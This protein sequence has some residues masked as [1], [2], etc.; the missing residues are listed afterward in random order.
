MKWQKNKGHRVGRRWRATLCALAAGM[1]ATPS[2]L[3]QVLITSV[4]D[5]ALPP[6]PGGGSVIGLEQN[7]SDLNLFTTKFYFN[8]A[9]GTDLAFAPKTDLS[10]SIPLSLESVVATDPST[11]RP[12]YLTARLFANSRLYT[13]SPSPS[14][15][16]V[17]LQGLSHTPLPTGLVMANGTLFYSRPVAVGAG[18]SSLDLSTGAATST[19]GNSGPGT[20]NT[21]GALAVGPDG[22]IYVL[23]TGDHRVVSFDTAGN[24]HSAFAVTSTA[25]ATA[26]TIDPRGYLYTADGNGGGSIYNTATGQ[27]YGTLAATSGNAVPPGNTL[28]RADDQGHLYMYDAATGMH[29][30]DISAVPEP[31]NSAV[32]IGMGTLVWAVAWRRGAVT[33]RRLNSAL[34]Q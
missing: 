34:A 14:T 27:L 23:D 20:L 2:L 5:S 12:F 6:F 15:D 26:L 30:F 3:A 28:L 16:V 18:I 31:I 33:T 21:P 22:L 13:F 4:T 9:L 19:F 29:V 25:A 7:G 32:V 17:N 1:V 8:S 10:L 11:D 24:Y